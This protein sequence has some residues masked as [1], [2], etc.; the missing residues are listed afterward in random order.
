MP[1]LEE[2]LGSWIEAGFTAPVTYNGKVAK[3]ERS[4]HT[5][6]VVGALLTTRPNADGTFPIA[7]FAVLHGHLAAAY[8]QQADTARQR[9]IAA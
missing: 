3:I 4:D 7:D 1:R 6:L 8:P 5:E 9:L 2:G